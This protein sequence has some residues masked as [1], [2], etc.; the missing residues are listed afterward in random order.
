[1]IESILI[2]VCTG[3][4]VVLVLTL[5]VCIVVMLVENI[6]LPTQDRILDRLRKRQRIA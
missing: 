4:A 5:T 2:A 6:I 3:V 1:M